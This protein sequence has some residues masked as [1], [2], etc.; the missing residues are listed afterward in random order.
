MKKMAFLHH[1]KVSVLI[2]E[3]NIVF[4]VVIFS[5][6]CIIITD[7]KWLSPDNLSN[8]IGRAS[9]LGLLALGQAI[10]LISLNFSM[11]FPK[12]EPAT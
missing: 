3:Y 12:T 5:I 9:I 1:Q 11:N 6:A 8:L 4:M 2:Q 10:V 7:G